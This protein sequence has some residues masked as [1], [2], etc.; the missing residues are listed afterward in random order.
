MQVA[1][2][3]TFYNVT[4]DSSMCQVYSTKKK[5]DLFFD[6]TFEYTMICML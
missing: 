2:K 1:F 4:F 6:E 5:V 3:P